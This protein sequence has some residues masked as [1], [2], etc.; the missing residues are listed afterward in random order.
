ML[1]SLLNNNMS[2][3]CMYIV[4]ISLFYVWKLQIGRITIGHCIRICTLEYYQT[5]SI[6]CGHRLKHQ[7]LYLDYISSLL[8]L[9]DYLTY[10]LSHLLL[11][12]IYPYYNNGFLSTI[13]HHLMC[14]FIF[15]PSDIPYYFWDPETSHD[16]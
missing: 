13:S 10:L 5:D 7:N 2:Y 15:H 8:I 9:Y 16:G 12:H 6:N 14:S 1:L 11:S 4:G 3:A